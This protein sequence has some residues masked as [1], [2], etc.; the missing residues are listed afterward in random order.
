MPVNL[1]GLPRKT[2]KKI[3][4]DLWGKLWYITGRECFPLLLLELIPY[5]T[6]R[7]TVFVR[8]SPFGV[9]SV[10]IM[11]VMLSCFI[12]LFTLGIMSSIVDAVP[13]KIIGPS[14]IVKPGKCELLFQA[15]AGKSKRFMRFHAISIDRTA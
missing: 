3:G 8:L 11:Y 10:R 5:S 12:I 7:V 15:G 14:T 9:C 1:T 4:L 6:T 13:L 2:N